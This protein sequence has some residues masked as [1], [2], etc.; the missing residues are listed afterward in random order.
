MRAPLPARRAPPPPRGRQGRRLSPA[1]ERQG[2]GSSQRQGRSPLPQ[3][4]PQERGRDAGRPSGRDA[5]L[6][7]KRFRKRAAGTRVVPAAGTR[8]S[9]ARARQRRRPSPGG[10]GK[11]FS[12]KPPPA[13]EV[14]SADGGRG[15][16]SGGSASVPPFR[17]RR[18]RPFGRKMDRTPNES[19]SASDG[20]GARR[21]RAPLPA[22][23]AP[24]PPK[25]EARTR[26]VPE[27][28]RR[29]SPASIS[30]RTRQGRRPP[31][32]QRRSPLPQA[33]PQESGGDAGRPSGRD[34]AL[35]RKRFRKSAARTQ[36]APAA[37]T[38]AFARR[39]AA[40]LAR[41]AQACYNGAGM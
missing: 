19:R 26:S 39:S 6:S 35:S 10:R 4:F 17:A 12:R 2:R 34:A 33:F 31:Q 11:N 3:A 14:P 23:R 13:G 24:P 41:A 27:A 9:L 25:G 30:A 36:A 28:G 7:R 38:R 20:N 22:H 29:L 15:L 37:G 40:A 8:A 18:K 32:R 5:A 16:L 21:T 1:R